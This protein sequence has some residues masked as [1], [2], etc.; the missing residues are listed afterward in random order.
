MKY[1]SKVSKGGVKAMAKLCV[2]T[3]IVQVENIRGWK[4][5]GLAT[6]DTCRG[7]NFRFFHIQWWPYFAI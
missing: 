4:F 5:C 1:I 2:L 6:P 3:Y 7:L